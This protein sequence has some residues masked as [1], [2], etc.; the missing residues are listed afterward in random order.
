MLCCFLISA[1][2]VSTGVQCTVS[3]VETSSYRWLRRIVYAASQRM[4]P[5][6]TVRYARALQRRSKAA[7]RSCECGVE[8]TKAQQGGDPPTGSSLSRTLHI[9]T[10]H[11]GAST[12]KRIAEAKSR[13][14]YL[15]FCPR[16][17]AMGKG[18]GKVVCYEPNQGTKVGGIFS[19]K[20]PTREKHKCQRTL[21]RPRPTLRPKC[22]LICSHLHHMPS[23]SRQPSITSQA[24][25]VGRKTLT[26]ATRRGKT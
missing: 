7:R 4:A 19:S 22:M 5:L 13:Y 24:V 11:A 16:G 3:V 26:T 25:Y 6:A 20:S 8:G 12:E 10:A 17:D 1:V 23:F 18:K 15:C 21:S 2:Y 14:V 9:T